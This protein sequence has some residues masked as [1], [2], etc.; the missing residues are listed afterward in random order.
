LVEDAET[1]KKL[2][3]E[4]NAKALG[5]DGKYARSHAEAEERKKAAG[6]ERQKRCWI[7][8]KN[9]STT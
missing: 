2:E 6:L 9:G 4:D 1:E 5:L 8:T 7:D 3:R